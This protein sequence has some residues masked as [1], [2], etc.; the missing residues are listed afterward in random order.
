LEKVAY[1][2]KSSLWSVTFKLFGAFVFAWLLYL[3]G[4]ALINIWSVSVWGGIL[5]TGLSA[6]LFIAVLILIWREYR[7][8][9]MVDEIIGNQQIVKD[10]QDK[11]DIALLESALS[12]PLENIRKQS[13]ELIK[14]F[15]QAS[16]TRDTVPEYLKQFDNI[17][18]T[19][20]DK[21]ADSIIQNEAYKSALAVAI[22]PHPS[23]DAVLVI[24]RGLVL[25]KAVA[26]IYGVKITGISAL[27][28]LKRIIASAIISAGV[29]EIGSMG[30]DALGNSLLSNAFKSLGE[31]TIIA[32]RFYRLG[33]KTKQI[34][35]LI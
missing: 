19:R 28:M 2:T 15:E 4:E 5:L 35:R 30:A 10:A 25:S 12:R 23:L 16:K 26:H 22:S 3:T 7:S 13:P 1:E 14:E 9:K 18:L 29:E 17:V 6:A 20:L 34:C 24:W 33:K 11:N 31:G 21:K 32:W 27:I 8:I